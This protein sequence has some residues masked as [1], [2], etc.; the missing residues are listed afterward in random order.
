MTVAIVPVVSCTTGLE[1]DWRFAALVMA[2]HLDPSLS[3]RYAVEPAAVLAEFGLV[4]P[5]GAPAP[6]LD[7]TRTSKLM[8]TGLGGSAQVAS[9]C[10][11]AA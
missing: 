8:I 1:H 5:T 4:L 11:Q 2:T 3:V 9:W 6:E 7:R 10:Y